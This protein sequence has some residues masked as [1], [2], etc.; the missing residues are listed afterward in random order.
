MCVAYRFGVHDSAHANGKR[1]FGHFVD[2]VVEEP[3]V[4]LQSLAGQ[5]FYSGPGYQRRT[6]F[7]ERYMTVWTDTFDVTKYEECYINWNSILPTKIWWY[8]TKEFPHVSNPF[9]KLI[10]GKI[11]LLDIELKKK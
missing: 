2:I 6:R 3:G 7:V 11:S 5:S 9:Q 8:L 10:P 4:C 1:L